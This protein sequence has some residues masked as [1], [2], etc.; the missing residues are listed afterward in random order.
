[1]NERQKLISK[2]HKIAAMMQ[3]PYEKEVLV[4]A[5]MLKKLLADHNTSMK[6]LGL[7]NIDLD[8]V[9][10]LNSNITEVTYKNCPFSSMPG[11]LRDMVVK[12]SRAYDV[13]ALVQDDYILLV[14]YFNDTEIVKIVITSLRSFIERQ[15][16]K[17]GYT[18]EAFVTSYAVGLV[19]RIV[20]SMGTTNTLK[21]SRIAAYVRK[22]W[23]TTPEPK[24]KE[25]TPVY[26]AYKTGM[27]DAANYQR[28]S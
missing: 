19:D 14:G 16:S 6:E 7:G 25:F 28:I 5:N 4:A 23:G 20:Q 1:M 15:I 24:E 11:W 3:S 9:A 26:G 27:A 22:C 8:R 21:E 2:A 12:I 18:N 17:N 13:A 10:E